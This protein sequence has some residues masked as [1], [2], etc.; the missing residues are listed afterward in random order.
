MTEDLRGQSC[1]ANS[2]A[3]PLAVV[4]GLLRADAPR[5]IMRE[6]RSWPRW[7][8][9]LPHVLAAADFLDREQAPDAELMLD[10]S[11]L[12]DR[13]GTY[14]Q[15]RARLEDALP[16]FRRALAI[17]EAT[18][19]SDHPEIA[20]TLNNLALALSDLGH[21]DQAQPLHER[22]LAITEAT[23]GLD[24]PDVAIRLTNL[25]SALRDLGHPDQTQPLIERALAIDE[26]TYGPDHPAVANDLNNLALTL[27]DLGHHHEAQP[28]IERALAIDEA[29]YG[30]DHPD[31]ATTLSNLA[32]ILSNLGHPDQAQ[33]LIERALIIRHSRKSQM[34][35]T[36]DLAQARASGST[37][38][39]RTH[40]GLR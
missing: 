28:L 27:S 26:A 24:H 3:H 22:A 12:L 38:R 25:A 9:L 17:N 36:S 4:V 5:D 32:L 7:A 14:L 10:A 23:H 20:T 8:V 29:T 31:V 16:L 19:S 11:W 18:Y 34:D 15:A 33:P 6:P 1:S 2:G 13:A 40:S 35:W 37:A 21:P 30:P 39:S